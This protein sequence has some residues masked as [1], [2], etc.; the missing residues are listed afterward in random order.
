V[1]ALVYHRYGSPEALE[2]AEV[3]TPKMTEGRLLIRVRAASVNRSDWESLTGRPA[4]VRMSGGMFKPKGSILGS[5]VAGVVEEVGD[6]VTDFTVGDRVF[7]DLLYYGAS[8]FAEYVAV[9]EKAPLAAIPEG[10]SF[11]QAATLPQSGALAL[12]GLIRVRETAADDRVLIVGAG[13]GG[14]TFAVQMA[15]ARGAEV[16]AVDN[17]GKM[18]DLRRLGA[19]HVVDYAVENVTRSNDRFDRVI[20]FVGSHSV[21]AFRRIL[22]RN[23]VYS[24]VGGPM[25]RLLGTVTFGW[26]MSKLGSKSLGVLLAKPNRKHLVE[27]AS[28]VVGGRLVPQIHHTYTLEEAARAL[29]DLGAGRVFGKAV[30]TP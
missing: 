24:I 7:G 14:G 5:D 10:L 3:P 22:A 21:F 29:E 16:T 25:R 12:Q 4:Y 6:G 18:E 2:L 23:G 30:I 11:E 1:R 17:S 8:C 15:R 26:L 19:D 20:D 28:E 13:G 9:S 27:V